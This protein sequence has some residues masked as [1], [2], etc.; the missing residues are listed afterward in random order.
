MADSILTQ[1][2]TKD[3]DVLDMICQ[4]HYANADQALGTV[5]AFNPGLSSY[6]PVLPAGILISLPDLGVNELK[7]IRLWS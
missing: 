1:Y 6:G 5:L 4:E 7:T 3:G 2:R